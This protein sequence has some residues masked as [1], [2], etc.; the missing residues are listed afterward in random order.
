MVTF[1]PRVTEDEVFGYWLRYEY[2]S[3]PS[4]R[5]EP[6]FPSQ[7][8]HF[9]L[10]P[11][12]SSREGNFWRYF[13]LWNYYRGGLLKELPGRDEIDWHS[14]TLDQSDYAELLLIASADWRYLSNGTCQVS[15]CATRILNEAQRLTSMP[16]YSSQVKFVFDLISKLGAGTSTDPTL[17]L[18]G[19]RN[20][21]YTVIDGVHRCVALFAYYFAKGNPGFAPHRVY[22]GVTDRKSPWQLRN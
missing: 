21:P 2:D 13:V 15:D 16:Q 1:G 6:G 3:K 5:T 22:L 12:Y 4:I 9:I 7:L 18:V 17:I 14:A 10:N 19:R 20:G 11:D 8:V